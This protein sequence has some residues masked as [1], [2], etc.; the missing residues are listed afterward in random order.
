[1]GW[2]PGS[3][4]LAFAFTLAACGGSSGGGGSG[5]DAA[6]PRD[7]GDATADTTH[8]ADAE[9]EAQAASDAAEDAPAE[10][11]D[12]ES[13]ETGADADA[14]DGGIAPLS[15]SGDMNEPDDSQVLATP[16]GMITDC[17]S[18]GGTLTSVS[19]GTGDVDWSYYSGSDTTGCAVDP[20]VQID[21]PDLEVCMFFVGASGTT[22]VSDCGGGSPATSPAG[23]P[24]CCIVSTSSMTASITCSN[25]TSDSADV[26]MRVRQL[27]SNVCIGYDLAYH[28]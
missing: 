17:D 18:S 24:G 26:Y 25:L 4:V 5:G 9:P 19:S 8:P 13:A 1:M 20:T 6:G 11:A 23:S 3:C 14:G 7:A 21:A 22:T 10:A 27:S 16:I 28:F 12:A 2:R 15:C